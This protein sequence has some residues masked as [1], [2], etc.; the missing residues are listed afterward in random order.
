MAR[1]YHPTITLDRG[2]CSATIE[3]VSIRVRGER[4]IVD[5][6]INLP[7]AT[8]DV[9][10]RAILDWSSEAEQLG[11]SS[12]AVI[13]RLAYLNYEPLVTLATAAAVTERVRLVANVV[14]GPLRTNNALLAKQA[15]T[16]DHLSQGRLVL[17]LGVGGTSEDYEF[18]GL[19]FHSRGKAFD[20]QLIE[21]SEFWNGM[22][23]GSETNE[24]V[25]PLPIFGQR[26]SIMIGGWHDNAFRRA[27]QY[28]DGWT[29]GDG[30]PDRFAVGLTRLKH[31]W[32]LAGRADTPRTTALLQFALGERAQRDAPENIRR[33]YV[34]GA[35]AQKVIDELITD[36]YSLSQLLDGFREAGADEVICLPA[37]SDMS[38]VELLAA[39]AGL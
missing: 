18:S 27:A 19:D 15:S 26:P 2:V 16:I 21:L 8:Q 10:R 17:G 33:Y 14:L 31:A 12:V 36:A 37:S 23:T 24:R 35:Y 30:G 29:M 39:A 11:F 7:N 5:I 1:R 9:D 28:A 25:G 32:E 22:R 6:G 3:S 34:Q 13:D 4:G 38:E 20:R